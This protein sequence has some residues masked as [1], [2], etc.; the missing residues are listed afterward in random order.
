M[1]DFDFLFPGE[2]LAVDDRFEDLGELINV[3]FALSAEGVVGPELTLPE[4]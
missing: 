1:E 4:G 3:Q 2:V